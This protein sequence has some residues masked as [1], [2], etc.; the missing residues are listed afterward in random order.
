[1]LYNP[2]MGFLIQFASIL[3]RIFVSILIINID[4]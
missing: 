2:L 1:M 3:L 4:L